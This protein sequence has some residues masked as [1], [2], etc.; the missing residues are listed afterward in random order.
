MDPWHYD[1]R[2]TDEKKLRCGASFFSF[3]PSYRF[4]RIFGLRNTYGMSEKTSIFLS[5]VEV[6]VDRRYHGVTVILRTQPH[7]I[8]STRDLSIVATCVLAVPAMCFNS[9]VPYVPT[10]FISSIMLHKTFF[11]QFSPLAVTFPPGLIKASTRPPSGVFFVVLQLCSTS[12]AIDYL[13]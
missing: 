13:S 6:E 2:Y 11:F 4:G 12:S 8:S 1:T 3:S 5:P 9:V 7:Q 10:L